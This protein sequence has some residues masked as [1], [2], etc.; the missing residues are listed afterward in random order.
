M[1]SH[2]LFCL[3]W[4]WVYLSCSCLQENDFLFHWFLVLFSNLHLI[5]FCLIFIIS[6]H[7]LICSLIWFCF[8]KCFRYTIRLFYNCNTSYSF[9]FYFHIIAILGVHCD[10]CKSS[11]NI[12]SL[13]SYPSSFSIVSPPPHSWN[14]FNMSLFSIFVHEY[15]VFPSHSPS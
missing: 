8:S 4:L 15:I 13:N 9:I 5:N 12:S 11:Y 3:F 14:S 2:T 7:P 10:I 1:S 6:F